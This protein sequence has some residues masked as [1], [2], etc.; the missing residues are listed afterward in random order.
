M[1]YDWP[2]VRLLA[3]LLESLNPTLP[4]D[5]SAPTADEYT[6]RWYLHPI[7]H[8]AE[9]LVSLILFGPLLILTWRTMI[10]QIRAQ[11]IR[12]TPS[13]AQVLWAYGLLMSLMLQI[14][15]KLVG[16]YI[17]MWSRRD[18]RV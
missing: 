10:K 11:R 18:L 16:I 12:Y 15:L 9:L 4:F 13:K 6:S 8:A 3:N 1:H 5:T 7:Q 14:P 17:Y 2:L